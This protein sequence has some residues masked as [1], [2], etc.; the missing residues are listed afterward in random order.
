MGRA[1]DK[2]K[3][4]H[5]QYGPCLLGKQM[6]FTDL[7]PDQAGQAAAV[8]SAA[9]LDFGQVLDRAKVA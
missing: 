8:K 6:R 5:C 3:L 1:D 4:T 2:V 9:A 7:D